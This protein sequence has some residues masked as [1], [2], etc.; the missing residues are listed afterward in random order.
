MR[1]MFPVKSQILISLLIS[2]LGISLLTSELKGQYVPVTHRDPS[3]GEVP[4]SKPGS[5]D[6]PGATYVLVKD[7]SS[8]KS[9]L[10]LGKDITLD[11]NGYRYR[12]CRRNPSFRTQ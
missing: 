11:L 5:Y 2:F 12:Y 8:S 3:A 10:F 6:I 9:A 1:Y 7:I 4:V